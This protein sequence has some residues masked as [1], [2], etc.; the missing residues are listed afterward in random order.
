MLEDLGYTDRTLVFTHFRIPVESLDDGLLPLMSDKDARRLVEC[1]PIFKE[2]ELYIETGVSLVECQMIE[3][4]TTKGKGVVIEEIVDHDVN[5]VVGK[6]LDGEAGNSGK[7]L[8]LECHKTSQPEKARPVYDIDSENDFPPTF[9][10]EKMFAN[11]TKSLSDGFQFRRLLEEIDQEFM[12]EDSSED[13]LESIDVLNFVDEGDL[14]TWISVEEVDQGIDV[15]WQDDPYHLV[16]VPEPE[17]PQEISDMFAE[18]DQALDELNDVVAAEKG[19]EMYAIFA[20]PISFNLVPLM[21]VGEETFT[22]LDVDGEQIVCDGAVIPNDL[23]AKVVGDEG[24]I[25]AVDGDVFTNK[26]VAK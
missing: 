16:D 17:E 13:S 20:E 10:A 9:C 4:M 7:L 11:H 5:D 25:S 24:F 18:I 12:V 3:R 14:H 1:V 6:D 15:E 2:L 23:C 21:V 26:V 19:T 22:I 8:L